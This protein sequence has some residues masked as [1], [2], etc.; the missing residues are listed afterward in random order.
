M[1][2]QLLLSLVQVTRCLERRIDD[3][4]DNLATIIATR[5][6]ATPQVETLT[7]TVSGKFPKL[8]GISEVEIRPKKDVVAHIA[9]IVDA[10]ADQ[11][12]ITWFVRDG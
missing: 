3:L 4:T 2:P 1:W 11:Y 7:I 12:G 9:S 10:N 8:V 6:M 5:P